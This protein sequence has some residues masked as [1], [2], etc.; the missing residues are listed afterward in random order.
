MKS[1]PLPPLQKVVCS[2]KIVGN[3]DFR[4]AG[5]MLFWTSSLLHVCMHMTMFWKGF[6]TGFFTGRFE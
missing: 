6:Y 3:T 2:V 5:I 1:T 4:T